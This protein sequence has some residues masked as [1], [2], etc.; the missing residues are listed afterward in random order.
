MTVD[1]SDPDPGPDPEPSSHPTPGTRGVRLARARAAFSQALRG[2]LQPE[3]LPTEASAELEAAFGSIG[4]EAISGGPGRIG[5]VRAQVRE[6]PPRLLDWMSGQVVDH[7]A[8]LYDRQG[9][10][11]LAARQS[12]SISTAVGGL[13]LALVTAAAAST[14]EGGPVLALAIDGAV[15]QVASVVHGLC[16]WYNTG[17]YLV[18]QLHGL[19]IA[20]D[21][22]EV[23]R[24]T[25]AALVSKGKVIDERSLRRSTELALVRN[26]V[27]HG[28]V[29]AL[30]FGSSLGRASL[31]ATERI[32]RSDLSS[33]VALVRT[34]PGGRLGD[35]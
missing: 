33:L 13:Q 30:P 6:A 23:R 34:D 1:R 5:R 14:L 2:L 31:R 18:R 25:N 29:D 9:V 20:A 22:G 24:L 35:G 10:E 28:I 11:Q 32:D 19:G 4:R 3:G 21:R 7:P 17:S 12:R 8:V 15:G 16:D 26:W 27:G